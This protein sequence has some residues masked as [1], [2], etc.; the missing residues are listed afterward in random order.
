M[1]TITLRCLRGGNLKQALDLA[2]ADREFVALAGSGVSDIVRL[3]AGLEEIADGEILFD[4]RRLNDLPARER[5]AAFL[6]HDYA[7][8][9]EMSVFDNL[10]VTLQHR[11]F[12][13]SEVKK[14]STAAA[15]ALGLESKLEAKP[16]SLSAEDQRFIGLARVM[17]RQPQVYLF[18]NPFAGLDRAAIER[19]RSV[20]VTLRQ[21][22]AATILYAAGD[23]SEALAF[24]ARTVV[25]EGG[26]VHQDADART[27]LQSP[28]NL[29]VA[30]LFQDP[31]MNLVHGSVK[32]DR[33]AFV[34]REKGDGTITV[35]WP[36]AGSRLLGLVE[37]PVVLGFHASAVERA[38]SSSR[39][40]SP[41]PA[42]FRAL[43]DRAELKGGG[44]DLYLRTGEHDLV[45]RSLRWA[46]SDQAGHRSEFVIDPD[47]I[48]VY[49]EVSGRL[50]T[51]ET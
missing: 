36:V 8:Y 12:A 11:K 29:S 51:P 42:L 20:V 43:I 33:D 1:G 48:R 2:V 21:R 31:P 5:D 45:C 40:G 9:P 34:F 16:A 30:T 24:G 6:S 17:V 19:G 15:Q 35:R 7:P 25:L 47:Q 32:R 22:A 49:D 26:T 4:D 39:E 46:G 38:G 13:G 14:R 41:S 18:D 10:A 28:A 27:V 50:L 37:G 3:I 23:L 44:T